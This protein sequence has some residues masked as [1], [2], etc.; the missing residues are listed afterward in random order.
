LNEVISNL[1][2]ISIKIKEWA[3]IGPSLTHLFLPLV[4]WLENIDWFQFDDEQDRTN[5]FPHE[6]SDSL[7]DAL[8]LDV[9]A[10]VKLSTDRNREQSDG[11]LK[12]NFIK[13]GHRQVE[14]VSRSFH[15]DLVL[16]CLDDVLVELA[17]SPENEVKDAVARF[18]PFLEDYL[19]L[20]DEQLVNHGRWTSA[21]LKLDYVLCSVM[22]TIT[23]DG[24]CKPPETEADGE[25]E[26]VAD[27]GDGIGLGVGTGNENVSKEIEDESQVE[28]L[29]NEGSADD[30]Q[31]ENT[32]DDGVIEMSQDIGGDLEDV[33]DSEM[34]DED[35]SEDESEGEVDEQVGK[36]DHKDPSAVDE[37]LWGDESG[38]KDL[39]SADKTDQDH[40]KGD[41]QTSDVV[42]KEKGQNAD[43]EGEKK[44][45]DKETKSGEQ[46]L[47]EDDIAND[48]PNANGAPMDDHIQEANTLDL[49]EDLSLEDDTEAQGPHDQE[50]EGEEISEDMELDGKDDSRDVPDFDNDEVASTTGEDMDEDD[51]QMQTTQEADEEDAQ[52]SDEDHVDKPFPTQPDIHTGDGK[53][54]DLAKSSAPGAPTGS[55]QRDLDSLGEGEQSLDQKD[56]QVKSGAKS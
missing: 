18:L 50:S 46:E 48:E 44:Q 53:G 29:Q 41:D 17:T 25:L 2:F 30:K 47:P 40:S 34:S 55:E 24:F 12:D 45:P 19:T 31:N 54:D 56:A 7:I 8:L 21:L 37:K 27:I 5:A 51:I 52:P 14:M 4:T 35:P 9:Q 16:K 1:Q 6:R 3:K 28:G 33:N 36:F 11:E 49:P 15:L 39:N 10:I 20:V 23:K 32:E 42:A 26:G 38:P 43:K 13:V 22:L